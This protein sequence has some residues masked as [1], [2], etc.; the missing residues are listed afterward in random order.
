MLFSTAQMAHHHDLTSLDPDL[1][2]INGTPLERKTSYKLLGIQFN[3]H[4]KWDEAISAVAS[5]CY[6]AT[7]VALRKV[8][9]LTPYKAKRQLSQCLI[10]SKIQF[11][12]AVTYPLS[13]VLERKLQKV[14]SSAAGFVLNKYASESDVLAIG[15]LPIR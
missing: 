11:C 5:S 4:L 8:K 13:A 1:V 6:A 2:H 14:Q 7:L 15:W 3:E 10:L 12:S 9:H